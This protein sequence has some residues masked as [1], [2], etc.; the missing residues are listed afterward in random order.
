MMKING[1]TM[2]N[3]D[4]GSLPEWFGVRRDG[5]WEVSAWGVI[6]MW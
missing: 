1:L 2:L 6:Q 5:S 4:P 3:V